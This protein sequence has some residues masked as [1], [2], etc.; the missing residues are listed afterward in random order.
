MTRSSRSEVN[1]ITAFGS[2]APDLRQQRKHSALGNRKAF[3]L[4]RGRVGERGGGWMGAGS[5]WEAEPREDGDGVAMGWRW[6]RSAG[7][8]E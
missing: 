8:G 3:R 1:A 6:R 2:D 4:V 7:D 5:G